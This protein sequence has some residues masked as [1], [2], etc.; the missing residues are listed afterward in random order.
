VKSSDPREYRVYT[1]KIDRKHVD[2]VLCNPE[3]LRPLAGIELDDKSHERADRRQR[4]SFVEGVFEAAGLAFARLTCPERKVRPDTPHQ[5]ECSTTVGVWAF[6]R[7]RCD[8]A[9]LQAERDLR[10]FSRRIYS[11]IVN[12]S[13]WT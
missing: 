8:C 6:I 12:L 11:P 7:T 3:T 1:N 2:F 5:D 9:D 4:D 10:S 13:W